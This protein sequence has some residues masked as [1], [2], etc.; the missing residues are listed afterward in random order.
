MDEDHMWAIGARGQGST[1][2]DILLS[3]LFHQCAACR[4]SVHAGHTIRA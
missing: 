2:A 1:G 3:V 4:P